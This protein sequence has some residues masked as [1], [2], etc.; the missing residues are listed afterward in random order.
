MKGLAGK[1]LFLY[2]TIK[3]SITCNRL[4]FKND[5][6]LSIHWSPFA[7]FGIITIYMIKLVLVISKIKSMF[8]EHPADYCQEENPLWWHV[9]GDFTF[10]Y[11]YT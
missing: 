3:S 1:S 5:L 8:P 11:W 10:Y 4:S 7:I 6:K 2:W 9:A